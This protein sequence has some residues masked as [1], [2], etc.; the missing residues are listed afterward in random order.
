MGLFGETTVHSSFEMGFE[1]GGGA[2]TDL[3]KWKK[4]IERVEETGINVDGGSYACLLQVFDVGQCFR[5]KRLRRAYEAIR[6]GKPSIVRA[7]G[8]RGIGGNRFFADAAKIAR[9][10][11]VIAAGVPYRRVVVPGGF[12][13]LVV[14]HGVEGHLKGDMYAANVLFIHAQRRGQSAAGALAA[15]HD[16]IVAHTQLGCGA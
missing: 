12:G 7:A 13:I 15:H 5:V 6:R 2:T 10:A 14:Q 1:G 8:R 9:P 3:Q 4:H 11:I 16:L